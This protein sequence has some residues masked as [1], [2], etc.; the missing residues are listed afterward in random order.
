MSRTRRL[1]CFLGLH[2]PK[3]KRSVLWG[4]CYHGELFCCCGL[5]FEAF[6]IDSTRLNLGYMRREDAPTDWWRAYEAKQL[7]A[8]LQRN[9]E[10]HWVAPPVEL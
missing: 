10:T 9:G 2:S 4:N 5:R 3:L 1:L 6:A 7:P 8:F